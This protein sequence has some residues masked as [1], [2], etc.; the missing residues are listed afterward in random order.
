MQASL[1]RIY[2]RHRQG[3]YTLSLSIT[4]SPSQAEDAIQEAFTRLW[5]RQSRPQ[6][7]A[8]AYVFAA[9]RNAAVDQVR[10]NR[11]K[12]F[13]EHLPA[14]IYDGQLPDPASAAADAEQIEAISK[15]LENLPAEQREV[16]VMRIYSGLKF[17]QIAEALAQPLPTITSRYRRALERLRGNLRIAH[18]R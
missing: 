15:A 2:R 5:K 14:S 3:L 13:F 18:G 16:I 10:R 7:D 1:E 9:V 12:R 11:S 6:G 4:R 8:I 17:A